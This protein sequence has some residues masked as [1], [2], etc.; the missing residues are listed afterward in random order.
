[1]PIVE[2]WRGAQRVLCRELGDEPM[3][4]GPERASCEL[5]LQGEPDIVRLRLWWRDGQVLW[6][7]L[8]P[9]ADASTSSP[10]PRLLVPEEAL[11]VGRYHTLRLCAPMASRCAEPTVP[12][13]EVLPPE[14]Q[15]GLH[16]ADVEE[17]RLVLLE[18]CGRRLRRSLG[19]ETLSLGTAPDNDLV[20]RD[21]T[22]S[23]HHCRIEP[24]PEGRALLRDLGSRNGTWSRGLRLTV[25]LLSPGQSV[26]LGRTLLRLQPRRTVL[27]PVVA[28][29][30]GRSERSA[31][32]D[33]EE[34]PMA[35]S[36]PMRRL[37]A[38]VEA[39]APLPWPL[40]LQG[41]SGSGKERIARWLHRCS[42]RS[43]GP[44]VAVNCGALPPSLLEGEL[45][46]H[47]RGAFTGAESRRKGMF[48]QAEGG[49]LLLDEI[50][51]MPLEQQARLL[52]V[53]ESGR[54]RRLG[55][56]R[57]VR[58]DVRIVA[59]T[60]RDLREAVRQG[61]F[62]ADLYCRL[63]R[64][65]LRV[66]PLRERLEEVE[67]LA[68]HAL[69]EL[70]P[71]LGRRELRREA[72]AR[73]L[74][75]PWPGNVRELQNVVLTAAVLARGG[76][77]EPEHVRL[78]LRRVALQPDAPPHP[79]A[80]ARI[81]ALFGGNVSAAARALGLPRG[82]FREHLRRAQRLDRHEEAA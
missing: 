15:P 20:L 45:F 37:I 57:E 75:Y 4:V 71:R 64:L 70:A 72:R 29:S 38:E 8:L 48:E 49:T 78:A 62:R 66:P 79:P 55:S 63:A 59:A 60:H 80:L 14:E 51:E 40:L 65:L 34:A 68:E 9:G 23:A 31:P 16:P 56:E 7:P 61:R 53:L 5:P 18:P 46:G 25:A 76:D 36:E 13:T 17:V 82:T 58:L 52:R 10:A 33:H 30:D 67:P 77:I 6:Q 74:A 41:E 12:R 1:M 26:R 35:L 54:V 22:V 81:V 28:A 50:G 11:P 39:L 27:G 3:E 19:T 42:E 21:R 47:E 69:G 44:F 73:L 32:R 2:L 24:L 43:E